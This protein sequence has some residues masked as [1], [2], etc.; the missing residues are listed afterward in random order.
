MKSPNCKKGYKVVH[1]EW[2]DACTYTERKLPDFKPQLLKAETWGVLIS[3]DKEKT[4][5]LQNLF[6]NEP[7]S[8]LDGMIVIPTQSI[9][10]K[11]ILK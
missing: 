10:K 11:E 5:I 3:E 8:Q 1:I 7:E 2:M 9:T 4:V 6:H